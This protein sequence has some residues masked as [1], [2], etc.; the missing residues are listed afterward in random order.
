MQQTIQLIYPSTVLNK[1]R[2]QS[3]IIFTTISLAKLKHHCISQSAFDCKFFRKLNIWGKPNDQES[4]RI[5]HSL[6]ELCI[7]LDRFKKTQD[8]HANSIQ[9]RK[10]SM[11]GSSCYR[12]PTS[13]WNQTTRGPQAFERLLFTLPTD[14]RQYRAWV[15]NRVIRLKSVPH[16]SQVKV[17]FLGGTTTFFAGA[18]FDC[19][20]DFDGIEAPSSTAFF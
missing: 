13:F 18:D 20:V 3:Q 6:I 7:Q 5:M 4:I 8:D 10:Q 16:R 19:E 11:F 15:T 1:L 14:W 17:V 12:M 2:I 9:N